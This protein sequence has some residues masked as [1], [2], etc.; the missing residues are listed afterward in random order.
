MIRVRH[1]IGATALAAWAV[2]PAAAQDV[3]KPQAGT[4]VTTPAA[5]KASSSR[6]A[7]TLS[8]VNINTATAEELQTLPGIGPAVSKRILDYRQ[9][10]GSFKKPEDLM[11]VRG[12][13]EKSFLKL[14]PLV[15]TSA[16][17]KPGG[18]L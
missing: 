9:K 6:K 11:N 15:I 5:K 2:S 1:L 14:K 8:P 3:V 7:T 4:A 18:G 16:A 17:G 10:N 13:G 12:I